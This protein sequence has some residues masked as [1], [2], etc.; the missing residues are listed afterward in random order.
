MN[1]TQTPFKQ[2]E[3]PTKQRILDVAIDLYA[4]RGFDAVSMQD[5]ADAVGIKKASLYYHFES[6]DQILK[7]ILQYP[8]ARISTVAPK[9][10]TEQ[11]ITSL[12]VDGFMSLS[13]ETVTSWI[14]DERMQ[15]VW[16]ILCIELYH[17][18]D[19]KR[20]YATFRDMSMSFWES[21][22]T[23]MRKHKLIKPL[24]PKVLAAEYLSF[25]MEALLTYFLYSYGSTQ[26]TLTEEY[27]TAFE[28]HT[29]FMISSIKPDEEVQ[30]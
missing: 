25:F 15:K 14:A 28:E 1:N 23:L 12:G 29:K 8:V 2:A 26:A 3:V 30:A 24:D 11:L 16:R 27:K 10:E 7:E 18:D 22:F 13:S 20:F 5:I 9:G 21:N 6:K 4:Q 17:N 19:I